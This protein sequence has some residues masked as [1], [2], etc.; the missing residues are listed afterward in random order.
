VQI[1]RR[2]GGFDPQRSIGEG[3]EPAEAGFAAH[4]KALE[5]VLA[6]HHRDGLG[7]GQHPQS[8]HGGLPAERDHAQPVVELVQVV[9]QPG[10][11]RAAIGEPQARTRVGVGQTVEREDCQARL[12]DQREVV[13]QQLELRPG[14][15]PT[16]VDARDRDLGF[17]QTIGDLP[18]AIGLER[19]HDQRAA[20]ADQRLLDQLAVLGRELEADVILDR[21]LAQPGLALELTGRE[22][23]ADRLAEAGRQRVGGFSGLLAGAHRDV[24]VR[25]LTRST[26]AQQGADQHGSERAKTHHANRYAWSTDQVSPPI[27]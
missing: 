23:L 11:R 7:V 21:G 27:G 14:R 13:E 9:A 22:L 18:R 15:S 1:Y 24:H 26:A 5:P 2:V 16:E 8:R 6:G 19:A 20:W 17:G 4:P 12:S 3:L 25:C 10:Q